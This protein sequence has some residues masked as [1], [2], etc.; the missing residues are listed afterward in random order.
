MQIRNPG[1]GWV[2]SYTLPF[3]F[4]LSPPYPSVQRPHTGRRSTWNMKM[5]EKRSAVSLECYRCPWVITLRGRHPGEKRGPSASLAVSKTNLQNGRF[6]KKKIWQLLFL[7]FW[8]F[9]SRSILRFGVS[10][11]RAKLLLTHR[12]ICRAMWWEAFPRRRAGW[13]WVPWLHSLGI[14]IGHDLSN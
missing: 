5:R 3:R 6:L 1:Q 7:Y 9:P 13:D 10:P 12:V 11:P 14:S 2:L 4:Y 8:G